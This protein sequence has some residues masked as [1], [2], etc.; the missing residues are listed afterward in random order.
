MNR[1]ILESV[2]SRLNSD[3][4]VKFKEEVAK[5]VSVDIWA[6]YRSYRPM[7][8]CHSGARTDLS[9]SPIIQVVLDESIIRSGD[10]YGSGCTEKTTREGREELLDEFAKTL[11]LYGVKNI[12][13]IVQGKLIEPHEV[14][15]L[16]TSF[17]KISPVDVPPFEGGDLSD[18]EVFVDRLR[19]RINT[20]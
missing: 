5:S 7:S 19:Q 2:I 14:G 8:V 18:L 20:S 6:G 16:T 11:N 12:D 4:L 17:L 15:F 13:K 1:N 10:F 3:F 9:Y